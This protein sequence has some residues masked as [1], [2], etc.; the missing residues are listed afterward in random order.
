MKK[1]FLLPLLLVSCT[2]TENVRLATASAT[3]L[4]SVFVQHSAANEKLIRDA[5]PSPAFL[6]A[7]LL[8]VEKDRLQELKLYQAHLEHL[9][10][11]GAVDPVLAQAQ[12]LQ[13]AQDIKDLVKKP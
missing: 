9:L 11:L 12:L 4:H 1:L 7:Y 13:V 3:Q 10:S 5:N 6:Q 2:S 8:E